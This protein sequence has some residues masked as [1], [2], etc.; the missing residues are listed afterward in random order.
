MIEPIGNLKK[1]E[2][3]K[4]ATH[5]CRH[6][7]TYLSH[8]SCY[9]KEQGERPERIGFYDIECSNLK[10]DYGIILTW[11]IK[12]SLSEDV[13]YDVLTP[14][15][16]AKGIEDKRVVQTAINTMMQFDK[17][18]GYYSSK[19]DI[20]FTRTR[21]MINGLK[22]PEAGTLKHQDLYYLVKSKF[23][24][25]SNRLENACKQIL[26]HTDKTRIDAKYWRQG[27][28][29]DPKAIEYILDHNTYDVLDLEKLYNHTVRFQKSRGTTI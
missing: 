22:F 10:A 14:E 4:L 26:E 7:H 5:Y 25:S 13:Y 9:F 27:L 21:A 17:I 18:V 15:D 2:I 11:C 29:G 3:V 16:V 24:L 12:D 19:F 1:A 23:C 6:G 28:A 8:R 20:P